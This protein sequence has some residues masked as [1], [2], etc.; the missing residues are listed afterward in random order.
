MGK[1]GKKLFGN[2]LNSGKNES[3]EIARVEDVVNEETLLATRGKSVDLVFVIDTTGSMS[4]KIKGLLQTSAKFVD[5]FGKLQMDS[6][7]AIVAFGDLTV[8]SDKIVATGFTSNLAT[9]KQSLQKIPRFSGGVNRGESSLEALQKAMALGFRER[10]VKVLILITDEPALQSRNIKVGDVIAQ[11]RE[12]E[13][14]TFVV[15]TPEKYYKDM[16]AHTGGK[17]YKISAHTDFTDLLEMFGDIAGKV[18]ETVADVYRLG[19]GKVSDYLRL[20]PPN[21]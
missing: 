17:W 4:D 12:R 6:R 14:L 5:R 1:T 8:R 2:L 15:A 7:I 21:K 13:M 9:T 10:A 16:A 18:S 19:D 20:N 11:L 3:R